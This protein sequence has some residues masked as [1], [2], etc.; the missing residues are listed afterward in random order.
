MNNFLRKLRF[1]NT[2]DKGIKG[3][4]IYS[5]LEVGLVMIGILLALYIND[6][7]EERKERVEE[8]KLLIG[9]KADL[10]KDIEFLNF[11]IQQAREYQDKSDSLFIVL[12][13]PDDYSVE[14]FFNYFNP[15][16]DNL[17][18]T[19]NSGNFD[20]ATSTGKIGH[21]EDEFIK[22]KLFDYYRT[23]KLNYNDEESRF[24]YRSK[25]A[26]NV[27]FELISTKEIAG[28]LG[29]ESALPALNIR[30]LTTNKPFNSALLQ[31]VFAFNNQIHSW[32]RYLVK[33]EELTEEIEK[34]LE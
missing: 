23:V 22:E 11:N 31:K 1:A 16:Q 34:E 12:S 24:H 13:N 19:T 27:L 15:L 8:Q 5:I 33:A 17:Y 7:N 29:Y 2:S 26:P 32:R 28:L 9:L 20:A 10:Q 14:D 3:Y 25:F 4:I 6:W 30:D 18:F 21:I